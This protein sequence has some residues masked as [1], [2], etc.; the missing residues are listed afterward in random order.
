[1]GETMTCHQGPA[2]VGPQGVCL[3]QGGLKVAKASVLL[4]QPLQ[5]S[6]WITWKTQCPGIAETRKVA[7]VPPRLRVFRR[8][9]GRAGRCEDQAP[10]EWRGEADA[11]RLGGRWPREDGPGTAEGGGLGAG[12]RQG[13]DLHARARTEQG[14][15]L[16][17]H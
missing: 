2:D 12:S 5:F 10:G 13:A 1:M 7:F 14:H 17:E 4:I 8:C 3:R 16:R 11:R 6:V 9:G 15:G